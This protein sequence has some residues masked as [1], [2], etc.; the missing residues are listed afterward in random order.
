MKIS[1]ADI[2]SASSASLRGDC[3][4]GHCQAIWDCCANCT[5]VNARGS[6]TEFKLRVRLDGAEIGDG[7]GVVELEM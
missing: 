3:H 6:K 1:G 4:Q 5:T 2:E 7:V